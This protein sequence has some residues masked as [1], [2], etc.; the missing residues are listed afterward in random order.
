MAVDDVTVT[1]TLPRLHKGDAGE[2]VRC[3]Q[4]MLNDL[5]RRNGEEVLLD[6]NSIHAGKTIARVSQFQKDNDIG[7]PD[8]NVGPKTW[9][10]L[11][12][13]WLAVVP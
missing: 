2:A 10:K 11:L 7:P 3:V 4:H 6:E 12:E 8:G 13:A 9:N 1:A 5:D